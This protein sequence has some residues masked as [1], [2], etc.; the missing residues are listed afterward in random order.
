MSSSVIDSTPIAVMVP[1]RIRSP[2]IISRRRSNRSESAPLAS[3]NTTWGALHAS[4]TMASA[5]GL[6]E[7]SSTCSAIATT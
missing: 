5:L 4:P 6:F 1:R 2:A 7:I 3:I